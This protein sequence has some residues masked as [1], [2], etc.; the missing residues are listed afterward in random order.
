MTQ[1]HFFSTTGLHFFR[2]GSCIPSWQPRY[3]SPRMG[4]ALYLG[5]LATLFQ[6]TRVAFLCPPETAVQA[7]EYSVSVNHA[8]WELL[9]Y[10]AH[11]HTTYF[12]LLIP[13]TFPMLLKIPSVTSASSTFQLHQTFWWATKTTSPLRHTS[14][15]VKTTLPT[16]RR[17]R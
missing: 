4:V 17:S 10:R 16:E 7:D 3:D 15:P 5:F 2:D 6:R 8:L 14:Q 1:V 9:M 12:N 13:R 11:G